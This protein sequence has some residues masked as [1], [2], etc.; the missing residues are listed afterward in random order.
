MATRERLAQTSKRNTQI[1]YKWPQENACG[2]NE[3]YKKHKYFKNGH[4]RTTGSNEQ[5]EYT[6]LKNGHKRK[7][8]SNEQ[9]EKHK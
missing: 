6:N 2:S 4:K 5:L 7:P 1:F 8:G 3:Q 9:Y